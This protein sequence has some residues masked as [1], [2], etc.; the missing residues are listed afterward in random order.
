MLERQRSAQFHS[1]LT[2]GRG[3]FRQGD[4]ANPIFYAPTPRAGGRV[5]FFL[6]TCPLR[7]T[8][9]LSSAETGAPAQEQ[10]PLTPARWS[11]RPCSPLSG[12]RSSHY[13]RH[14]P[15]RPPPQCG[16]RLWAR[17]KSALL[18]TVP[19]AVPRFRDGVTHTRRRLVISL[20]GLE[21]VCREV[22]DLM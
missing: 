7:V 16:P 11:L 18:R 13:H 10:S 9:G 17:G 6:R 19:H 1:R 14:D 15:K 3:I 2:V 5:V 22:W 8:R 20:S 4:E 12:P 21:G